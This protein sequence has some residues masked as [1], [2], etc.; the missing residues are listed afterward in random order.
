M[1]H[2]RQDDRILGT[3]VWVAQAFLTRHISFAIAR[4]AAV[5]GNFRILPRPS[6]P[7][8]ASSSRLSSSLSSWASFV[9]IVVLSIDLNLTWLINQ[10]N[11]E[12]LESSFVINQDSDDDKACKTPRRNKQTEEALQFIKSHIFYAYGVMMSGECSVAG[13]NESQC[14]CM[15]CM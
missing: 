7:P 10:I 12:T 2:S 3:I 11:Q 6:P 1:L 9:V 5:D 4:T 13:M 14:C 8:P 15:N